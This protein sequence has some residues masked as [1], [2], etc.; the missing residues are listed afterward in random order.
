MGG[1]QRDSLYSRFILRTWCSRRSSRPIGAHYWKEKPA[2]TQLNLTFCLLP[3]S[4]FCSCSPSPVATSLSP[5][6]DVF[7]LF[8]L[9]LSSIIRRT[10]FF[11]LALGWML[12]LKR[13]CLHF[14]TG[15]RAHKRLPGF[16]LFLPL[17]QTRN[18]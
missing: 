11:F 6:K 14:C 7:C 8:L 3:C 17:K 15:K 12:L 16:L 9:R 10:V 18:W 1:R 2:E 5:A 4:W 13:N